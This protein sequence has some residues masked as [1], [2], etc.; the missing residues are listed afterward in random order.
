MCICFK[1]KER[2]FL[3]KGLYVCNF[4]YIKKIK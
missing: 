3:K 1:V 2:K 4:C